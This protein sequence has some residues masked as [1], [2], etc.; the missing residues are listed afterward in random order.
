[1]W[2][3]T[4]LSWPLAVICL[5]SALM[6]AAASPAG[7]V[8]YSK[9]PIYD[10][11][12]LYDSTLSGYPTF[13]FSNN[14][15]IVYQ[16]RVWSTSLGTYVYSLQLY[17]QGSGSVTI[18]SGPGSKFDVQI[19][20]LGQVVWLELDATAHHTRIYIYKNGAT[21]PISNPSYDSGQP[22]LNNQ[23]QVVYAA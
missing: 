14:G 4:R 5:I 11:F 20:D 22:K 23:G 12:T 10:D 21:I 9:K 17:R 19:N 7:A 15:D 2:N 1:M 18:P 6:I 16:T 3:K 13:Q 8:P